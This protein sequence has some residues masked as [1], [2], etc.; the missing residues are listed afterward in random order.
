MVK[1]EILIVDVVVPAGE[2]IVGDDHDDDDG[3]RTTR[4][5]VMMV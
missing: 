2:D 4:T 5:D 3:A 1:M